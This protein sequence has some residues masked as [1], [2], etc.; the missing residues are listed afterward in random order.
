MVIIGRWPLLLVSRPLM[1]G[2][3]V[4]DGVDNRECW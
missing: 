1:A 3:G 4:V 2:N